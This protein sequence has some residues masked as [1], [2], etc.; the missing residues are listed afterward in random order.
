MEETRLNNKKLLNWIED[1]LLLL[2]KENNGITKQAF[3]EYCEYV[4]N[5]T[6]LEG[7]Y[8]LKTWAHE[9]TFKSFIGKRLIKKLSPKSTVYVYQK[10][11]ALL[12]KD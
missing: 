12:E 4:G 9:R 11:K 8:F 5:K 3:W 2:L 7:S 10:Q 1:L 6:Y